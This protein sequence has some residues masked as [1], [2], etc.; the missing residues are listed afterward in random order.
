MPTL[1]ITIEVMGNPLRRAYVEH[2]VAGVGTAMYMTDDLGRVRDENGNLGLN[3]FTQNADIRVLCQNSVVKVLDGNTFPV[4]LTV[5]Q[6]ISSVGDNSVINLNTNREQKDHFRILNRCLLVYDIVFRQFRPFSHAARRN[7]PLGRA[8]SLRATKDR[9][10]RIEVSYPSQFLFPGLLPNVTLLAFTEPKSLSTSYPL[11]HIRDRRLDGRLFGEQGHLPTLIPA[12]LGHG[13]HFSLFSASARNG[14]QNDF[15]G[16]IA[17]DIVNGGHGTHNI[18]MRTSSKVAYIEALDHFSSRFAM[19]VTK[20]QPNGGLQPN[21]LVQ[22]I[23]DQVRREFLNREVSVGPVPS[24]IS[25]IASLGAGGAINPIGGLNGSDDEGSVYGCIFVDFARRVGLRTAVNAYLRSAGS[26][27]TTFGEY[28][29]WI[30]NNQPQHLNE[31]VAAQ[32]TWGL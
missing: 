19:F 20:T 30:T 26:G 4:P 31:L 27:A 22:P 2:I 16:W 8:S 23:T 25:P 17:S 12:E 7:F 1:N 9:R 14:I 5:F 24:V 3:S 29:T 10:Q 11:M 15:I 6:D 28:K 18:G 13:L 32:A 21:G